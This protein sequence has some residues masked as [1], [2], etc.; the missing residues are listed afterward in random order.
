[1]CQ[2]RTE[3]R[4]GGMPGGINILIERGDIKKIFEN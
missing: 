3:G 2:K 1:M 4:G